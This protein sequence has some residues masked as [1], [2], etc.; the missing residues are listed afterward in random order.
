VRPFFGARRP[1]AALAEVLALLVSI[2]AYASVARKVDRPAA[3][4]VVPYLGWTTFAA[5]L[6]APSSATTAE[7]APEDRTR[8]RPTGPIPSS[9]EHAPDHRHG[10]RVVIA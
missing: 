7:R 8:T 6:N 10:T 4:L 5:L 2:G 1:R 3:A 9:V